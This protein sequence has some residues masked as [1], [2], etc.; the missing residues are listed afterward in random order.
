MMLLIRLAWL[1]LA[2]IH[3]LPAFGL[4][5]SA[6]RLRLY[7]VEPTGTMAILL[8]HRALI[9]AAIVLVSLTAAAVQA[10][11]PGAAFAVSVSVVSF[12]IAYALGGLPAGA[13]RQVALVDC[14]A[15]P[16]LILVWIDVVRR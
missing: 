12:L 2:A 13:L 15:V 4:I 6:V 14:A 9:F 10:V 8:S 7:G 16:L 3:L 11:R 5:S 1:A